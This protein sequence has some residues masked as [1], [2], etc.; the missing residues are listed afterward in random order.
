MGR[1]I[2]EEFNR[3][4]HDLNNASKFSLYMCKQSAA[5]YETISNYF[6]VM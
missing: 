4:P 1:F 5:S 2:F 3:V 6:R